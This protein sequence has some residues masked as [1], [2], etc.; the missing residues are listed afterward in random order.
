VLTD[1]QI[2]I[3]KATAPAVAANA[4]AITGTFYP[5]MFSRFPEVRT[6]FNQ[7]HQRGG[8]QPQ[9]L[10]NAIIA[11][12]SNIDNLAVLGE[13]VRRIVE[14]HVSLNI[15]AE[16]YD[17]V[18]TCLM[19]AIGTVLGDAVTPEVADAWGA[20][21]WQLAHIL[22]AAEEAEYQRK[23][24]VPGGWR[25]PRTVRVVRKQPES[26]VITSFWLEPVDGG[27]LMD[28]QPG[29]YIGLKLVIDGETLH[30]NYSLSDSPNGRS[31]RISVKREPEGQASV[32]L[33]DRVQEGDTFDIYP[34][35]GEFTLQEGADPV[36]LLTAGVGQTPALSMLDKAAAEGRPVI[37]LHA[38]LNGKVH[39]FRDRVDAIVARAPQVRRAYIY[40]EPHADD[41]PD[42]VGFVTPDL[43]EQYLPANRA[44]DVYFLGPKPFMRSVRQ[45]LRDLGVADARV[46]YEFFGP[47][48]ALD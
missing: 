29:Q 16:Q 40:S 42:H 36:V 17:I 34:P 47:L 9:A 31:Y 43:L 15:T 5:L 41:A 12:A 21:Y 23:A 48:E 19:E 20:A 25:G 8:A 35:A 3:I 22:I 46:R 28:F 14:K 7:S 38:A 44:A 6:V 2:A 39:A 37:Y 33:H 26:A 27:P 4:T 1:A 13:A 24:A 32:Y 45:S 30:R 18:G 11:Y 10:A